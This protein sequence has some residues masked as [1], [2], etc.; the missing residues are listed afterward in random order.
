M[1]L[2]RGTLAGLKIVRGVD[3]RIPAIQGE[4]SFIAGVEVRLLDGSSRGGENKGRP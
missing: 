2:L 1:A 3:V 4:E